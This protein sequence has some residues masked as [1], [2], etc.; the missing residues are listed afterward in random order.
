ML[1]HYLLSVFDDDVVVSGPGGFGTIKGS[2]LGFGRRS[3][4][5]VE[6]IALSMI[7]YQY[8]SLISNNIVNI[9]S[10]ELRSQT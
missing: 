5:S 1:W 7:S 6:F 2:T 8:S 3:L 9:A 4:N 10:E